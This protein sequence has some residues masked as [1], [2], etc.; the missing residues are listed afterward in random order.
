MHTAADGRASL[1]QG[2][3][4]LWVSGANCDAL[5]DFAG[6]L[7][8]KT[9]WHLAVCTSVHCFFFYQHIWRTGWDNHIA[10]HPSGCKCVPA[11]NRVCVSMPAY[12]SGDPPWCRSP[13]AQTFLCPLAAAAT[14]E[15]A[16]ADT[17]TIPGFEGASYGC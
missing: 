5:Q 4:V 6:V 9:V 10:A 7:P 3:G 2:G 8:A 14:Q 12:S 15:A 1:P 11:S 16:A 17:A 13:V